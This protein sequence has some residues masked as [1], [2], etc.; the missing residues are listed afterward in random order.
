MSSVQQA[1]PKGRTAA[2]AFIAL[3]ALALS[4]AGVA[5]VAYV[6]KDDR[7]E[8][9]QDAA[10]GD[11]AIVAAK[12]AIDERLPDAQETEYGKVFVHWTDTIPSVCGQ[13]DITE[14]VDSFDGMERFVFSEGELSLE[15]TEG[16]AAVA[17]KWDDLCD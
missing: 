6:L 13:V 1:S 16:T 10:A 8:A 3:M 5:M 11:A 4:G 7:A 17:Q 9:T 2:V 14:A 15:Q 12:A